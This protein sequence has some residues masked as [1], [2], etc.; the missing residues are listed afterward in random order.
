MRR[1]TDASVGR[2]GLVATAKIRPQQELTA[3]DSRWS[4]RESGSLAPYN[5]ANGSVGSAASIIV[6][7]TDQW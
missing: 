7:Y 2:M 6:W 1:F 3:R 4:A 5:G